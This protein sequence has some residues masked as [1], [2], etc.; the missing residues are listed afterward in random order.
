MRGAGSATLTALAE[1]RKETATR[2]PPGAP[3]ELWVGTSLSPTFGGS[4]VGGIIQ[5]GEDV[6]EL[7]VARLDGR[8]VWGSAE[9]L[10][11]LF[12]SHFIQGGLYFKCAFTYS[13]GVGRL[14]KTN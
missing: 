1:A 9:N 13:L 8:I 5:G 14:V 7:R 3:H 12:L 2:Q 10:V 4:G 11:H 6:E